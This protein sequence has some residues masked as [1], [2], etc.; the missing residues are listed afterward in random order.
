M[1][2]A[3]YITVLA[4]ALTLAMTA[5]GCRQ[6]SGDRKRPDAK[7]LYKESVELGKRYIDSINAAPD[8]A[9]V[10]RLRDAYD[11]EAT[12]INYSYP[13]DTYLS[14]SESEN[15]VLARITSNLLA[16]IHNRQRALGARP[17]AADSISADS[18]P[19]R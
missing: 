18:I 14:I 13:P 12:K 11:E 9:T 6:K 19:Q 2:P 10:E 3:T 4:A 16:T 8:S 7:L 5:G 1:R 15:E 17:Q